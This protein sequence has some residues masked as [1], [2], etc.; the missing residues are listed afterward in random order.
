MRAAGVADPAANKISSVAI[1]RVRPL[2]LARI[3]G[4]ETYKNI[5][6]LWAY[7]LTI[8]PELALLALTYLMLQFFIGGGKLVDAL[9]PATTL[10]FVFYVFTYY[11]LAKVVSGLLEEVNT[12]TLEQ[13]HLSPLP[14]WALSSSRVGAAM[15]QGGLVTIVTAAGFLVALGI[16]F[17]LRWQVLVPV[18]VT[19]LDVAGFALLIAGL[20]LTIASIG[21]VLHVIQGMV[22]L[23]NGSLLPVE[24][25]PPWL[26]GVARLVPGTLG[27]EATRAVLF[28]GA[29]L[30]SVWT[31]GTLGWT[32]LHAAAMLAVGWAVYQR[33]IGRG[34]RTGRLGP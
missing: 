1:D 19:V 2:E 30:A 6:T 12:G 18:A 31:R 11:T 10:A 13:T 3:M 25:F 23:L 29:S 33:A 24:S 20:A 21:A 17:P 15:V 8:V 16:D 28:D 26:E 4:N 14:S 7:R 34:L 5:L 32:I 9:L 22:M 27:I